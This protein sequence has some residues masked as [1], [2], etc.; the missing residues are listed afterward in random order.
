MKNQD[1]YIKPPKGLF[2]LISYF[3][4]SSLLEELEGDM[5]ERFDDNVTHYGV[6]KARRLYLTDTIKLLRPKLLKKLSG[7]YSLTNYGMLTNNFKIAWRQMLKQKVL[8]I[9]KIGGFSTGIA[10]CILIALYVEHQTSYDKH[11]QDS[12][13]IFRLINKWSDGGEP[14][15]WTSVQ[16]PLKKV[17]EENIP[18]IDLA[19]RVVTW[20]WANAGDNHMRPISSSFNTYE[21]G[22]LYADP[23]LLEIL[24]IPMIYGSSKTALSEPNRIVISRSKADV[25]FP[26]QNPVGEQIILNND[27]VSY[28]IGGVMEDFPE[29]SHLQGDF[30]M[31]LF[32]RKSGPGT[33]GWCCTNYAMYVKLNEHADKVA[34][35]E[36]T[37]I[38]RNTL[39]IEKLR[40]VEADG[41][42]EMLKYQSYYLQPVKNIYLNPEKAGDYLSHGIIE[43][44]WVFGFI[45]VIILIIACINFVNL[46]VASSLSRSKEIG[47]LKVVGSM[48]KGLV[49]R[50]LSESCLYSFM[51]VLCALLLAIIAL[52]FFND[53]AGVSLVIPWNSFGFWS[54][55]IGSSLVIGILSGIYPALILSGFRP[56]EAL[57]GNISRS[58]TPLIQRGLVVFQFMATVVL[59][60]SALVLHKQFQYLMTQPLGYDKEQIINVLGLNTLDENARESFKKELKHITSVQNASLSDFIPVEGSKIQNRSFWSLGRRQLDPGVEAARWTVDEDYLK[61][62]GIN[63]KLGRDFR[64]N[65]SDTESIIIN[66]RMMEAMRLEDPIG[67][68]VSDMFDEVHTIIGVVDNFYFESALGEIRPLAMVKGKGESTLSIKIASQN[69]EA[70]LN[71]ISDLWDTFSPNQA[72][73]F[74]FMDQQY[75]L[76]YQDFTRAKTIF[77]LFSILSIVIACSGLFALSL[78]LIAR[79]SKEISVRKVLGASISRILLT[80]TWGFLKLILLAILIAVPIADYFTEFI[81]EDFVNR[82]TVDWTFFVVGGLIA[83]FIAVGTISL[84]ALKAAI[85]NPADQ[86]RNE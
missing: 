9:I 16:G 60:I 54:I 5:D 24:E 51:A 68:H 37:G 13:Q 57:K 15:Y 46:S 52:P 47:L 48:K 43:L 86:L 59:I 53:L 17:L 81:L 7:D 33:S 8:S 36:K 23:E 82:I 67:K 65:S 85:S 38:L 39:V 1:E 64:E 6:N 21:K 83:S 74:Q 29:N 35:E 11:Y 30:I 62:M 50:Y 42:D 79:R 72:M 3:V 70:S 41:I 77:I 27:T 76:M 71:S 78:Y 14:G 19:A 2:K 73:R 84:E 32:E 45:A 18:E 28:T 75:A 34:V 25:Y 12:D 56:I 26:N 80:L 49:Y 4:K 66:E 40:E 55:L 10:A 58:G 22:F 63:L 44:V 69:T 61:T 31:T 20:P